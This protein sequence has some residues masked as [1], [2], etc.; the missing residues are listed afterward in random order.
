MS[1]TL[2]GLNKEYSPRSGSWEVL[3]KAQRV[4]LVRVSSWPSFSAWRKRGGEGGR[5]RAFW[6]VFLVLPL[7]P[8]VWPHCTII[9]SSV[10]LCIKTDLLGIMSLICEIRDYRQIHLSPKQFWISRK[11]KLGDLENKFLTV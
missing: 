7:W 6:W 11:G 3:E 8:H 4:P 1:H 2:G 9:N 5:E 10:S